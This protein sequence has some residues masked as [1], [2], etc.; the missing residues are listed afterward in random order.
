MQNIIIAINHTAVDRPC[1]CVYDGITIPWHSYQQWMVDA[2]KTTLYIVV[3][4]HMYGM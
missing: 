1:S 4:T 2:R 3:I